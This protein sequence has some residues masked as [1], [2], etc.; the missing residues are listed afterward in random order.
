M[1][2]VILAWGAFVLS[3]FFYWPAFT[4]HRDK[5]VR[6]F[7]LLLLGLACSGIFIALP[8]GFTFVNTGWTILLVKLGLGAV[9]GSLLSMLYQ[10]GA[11]KREERDLAAEQIRK[12]AAAAHAK[13]VARKATIRGSSN[14]GFTILCLIAVLVLAAI[15][16]GLT[17][18]SN[19]A[20][21]RF[22][23]RRALRFIR[24]RGK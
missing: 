6:M 21:Q 2:P 1:H 18:P 23:K 7:T 15:V 22:G 11:E 24:R 13:E 16:G 14:I 8:I 12:A 17:L 9:V 5:R 4:I 10:Y 20:K 3:Y 19:A